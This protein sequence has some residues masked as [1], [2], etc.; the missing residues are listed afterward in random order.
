MRLILIVDYVSHKCVSHH[1]FACD[2][3]R[4]RF[5]RW[6][7]PYSLIIISKDKREGRTNVRE[8]STGGTEQRFQD[9]KRDEN[10]NLAARYN[11]RWQDNNGELCKLQSHK[12]HWVPFTITLSGLGLEGGRRAP[13]PAMAYCSIKAFST[14]PDTPT[15]QR[16]TDSP[17]SVFPDQSPAAARVCESTAPATTD[18]PKQNGY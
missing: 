7:W 1:P 14:S 17:S 5:R 4:N 10:T 8:T 13:P 3:H 6:S 2:K 18:G 12:K 11:G 9:P 15:R 16:P